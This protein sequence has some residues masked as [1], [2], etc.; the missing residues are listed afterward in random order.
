MLTGCASMRD[1]IIVWKGA[2]ARPFLCN[3]TDVSKF[4]DRPMCVCG[5][6]SNIKIKKHKQFND[7]S[8]SR[9]LRPS[10]FF[11]LT[12]LPIG[13]SKYEN[14]FIF[15]FLWRFKIT[16]P[17]NLIFQRSLMYLSFF[18]FILFYRKREV[19]NE[20]HFILEFQID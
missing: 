19:K 6:P 2:G 1:V 14:I 18:F 9:E 7:L 4:Q 10:V 20:T 11:S 12:I 15:L 5:G 3:I 16:W 17:L 13:I 8:N